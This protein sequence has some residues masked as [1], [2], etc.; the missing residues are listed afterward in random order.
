MTGKQESVSLSRQQE[1]S[2]V[3]EQVEEVKAAMLMNIEKVLERGEKLDNLQAM[4]EDLQVVSRSFF[5]ASASRQQIQTA[6]VELKEE[7]EEPEHVYETMDIIVK[8]AMPVRSSSSLK[9]KMLLPT[10]RLGKKLATLSDDQSRP[11]PIGVAPPLPK[12]PPPPC[13]G[14]PPSGAPPPPRAPPPPPGAPPPP[15]APP[16]PPGAPP[17][18]APPP[19]YGAPP[20][21]GAPSLFF[22]E[23]K[24][25]RGTIVTRTA[26]PPP[27]GIATNC[28]SFASAKPASIPSTMSSRSSSRLI[29]NGGG[30]ESFGDF[31]AAAV[32]PPPL[33]QLFGIMTTIMTLY[34]PIQWFWYILQIDQYVHYHRGHRYMLQLENQL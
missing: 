15:R 2:Q 33:H 5:K 20:P 17:P 27:R 7:L 4:S 6:A 32:P 29:K 13:G 8:E 11:V 22:S 12:A 30:P 34:V 14:P 31:S 24:K 28:L 3:K 9:K 26:G 23:I 25:V 19:P 21:P 10:P 18:K 16:P 1:I